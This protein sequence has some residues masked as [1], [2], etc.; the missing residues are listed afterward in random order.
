MNIDFSSIRMI[1]H[2]G[3]SMWK[4]G[5]GTA[6]FDL[7]PVELIKSKDFKAGEINEIRKLVIKNQE[8]FKEKWD[9]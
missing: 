6:K 8:L 4:V 7:I 5:N 2:L 1:I 9:E 3:I